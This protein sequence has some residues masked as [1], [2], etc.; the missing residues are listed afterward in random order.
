MALDTQWEI[1]SG[2]GGIHMH[3]HA[4]CWAKVVTKNMAG[5]FGPIPVRL[6]RFA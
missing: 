4:E 1:K 2:L 3:W 5:R 6:T